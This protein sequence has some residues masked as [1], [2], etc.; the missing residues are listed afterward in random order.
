MLITSSKIQI[1]QRPHLA[2]LIHLT[3][4]YLD[5]RISSQANGSKLG[6]LDQTVHRCCIACAA[7][8]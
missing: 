5:L 8:L 6:C 1:H 7:L 2:A 4:V 3:I